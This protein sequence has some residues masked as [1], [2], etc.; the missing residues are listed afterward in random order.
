MQHH[1]YVP[2]NIENFDRS[3]FST[4]TLWMYKNNVTT[5]FLPHNEHNNIMVFLPSCFSVDPK[6]PIFSRRKPDP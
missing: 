5:Q 6:R 2:Y 4:I 1:C 3:M